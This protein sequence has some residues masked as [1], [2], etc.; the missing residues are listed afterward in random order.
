MSNDGWL[1]LTIDGSKHFVR[2]REGKVE[3]RAEGEHA[4]LLKAEWDSIAARTSH[5]DELKRIYDSVPRVDWPLG[6]RWLI[7]TPHAR[8]EWV[9]PDTLPNSVSLSNAGIGDLGSSFTT[10][11]PSFMTYARVAI[12]EMPGHPASATRTLRMAMTSRRTRDSTVPPEAA[13]CCVVDGN[14]LIVFMRAKRALPADMPTGAARATAIRNVR[15]GLERD[16][17]AIELPEIEGVYATSEGW[18]ESDFVDDPPSVHVYRSI[19]RYAVTAYDDVCSYLSVNLPGASVA[20]AT[21][22]PRIAAGAA[23]TTL[24]KS[25]H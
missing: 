15:Q 20:F 11:F 5:K 9:N 6:L 3:H 21:W 8:A 12:Y 25:P 23:P 19:R 17:N 2:V 24:I 16:M 1:P 10:L 18:F 4:R 13:I 14:R 22:S 7:D